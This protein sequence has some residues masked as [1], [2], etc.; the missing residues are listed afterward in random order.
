MSLEDQARSN[1]AREEASR[2]THG[3]EA[4]QRLARAQPQLREFIAFMVSHQVAPVPLKVFD[5]IEKRS[6]LGRKRAEQKVRQIGEGW[7]VKL[8]GEIEPGYVVAS[9][10]RLFSYRRSNASAIMQP[11]LVKEI[12]PD[13]NLRTIEHHIVETMQSVI[14]ASS[15]S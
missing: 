1:L 6:F 11:V 8:P 14:K 15:G 4:A 7:P 2:R 12:K 13:L 10:G 9:D 3:T 5:V